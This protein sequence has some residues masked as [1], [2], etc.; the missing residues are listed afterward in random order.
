MTKRST[1]I[2]SLLILSGVALS[3]ASITWAEPPPEP[4]E[5][6]GAPRLHSGPAI[7]DP[8]AMF[9]LPRPIAGDQGIFFSMN[10]LELSESQRDKIFEIS[11][12]QMPAIRERLK[13][14]RN[15]HKALHELAQASS[16]DAKRAKELADGGA[17]AMAELAMMRAEASNKI[18][19]VFTPE[20]RKKFDEHR[21]DFLIHQ[22]MDVHPHRLMTYHHVCNP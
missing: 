11:Y 17:K 12:A 18:R 1:F 7:L 5:C 14:V 16:F 8:P 2:V 15:M 4:M 13:T 20:Q 3:A 21:G 6:P 10:G 22:G 9:E 19:A